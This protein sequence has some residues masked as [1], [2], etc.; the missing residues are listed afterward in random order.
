[1]NSE[2][3][4][5]FTELVPNDRRM[6]A[7]PM[8]VRCVST[9]VRSARRNPAS[10]AARGVGVELARDD[11]V[12]SRDALVDPRRRAHRVV[13]DDGEPS[14]DILFGDL[15]EDP[16]AGGGEGDTHL[17][18]PHRIGVRRHPRVGELGTREERPL[19]D[20]DRL[21]HLRLSV[22]LVAT[23][24]PFVEELRPFRQLT[25]LRLLR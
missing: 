6:T 16:P 4:K 17:P 15:A 1:M 12:A 3:P 19:L 14:P 18:V 13:E 8:T 25:S 22:F 5:P 10:M 9:I 24:R 20:D 7:V 21:L 11:R 2:T 23:A